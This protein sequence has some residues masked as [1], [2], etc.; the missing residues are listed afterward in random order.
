M[1]K[2][3][4]NL[5][6]TYRPRLQTMDSLLRLHIP[7]ISYTIPK[8]GYFFWLR[9]PERVNTKEL[10]QQAQVFKVDFRQGTLFSCTGGSKNY[11]RLCFAHYDEAHI[12][13]G[14]LRLK[15][16]LSDA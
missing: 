7:N 2:N 12:E 3:I 9:F 16:C 6:E 14:I 15:K 8:G 5:I 1:Q 4:H 11:V 13:E 10:R